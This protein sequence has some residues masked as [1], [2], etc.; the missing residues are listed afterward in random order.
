MSGQQPIVLSSDAI[1][2]HLLKGGAAVMPTDTLPAMAAVPAHAGQLWRLKRRPREKPLILM[3]ASGEVLL[4]L[5]VPEAQPTASSLAHQ[6]WPGALTLVVP[7]GAD[8][9]AQAM[10]QALNPAATS[11]GLRV[12]ACQQARALL[13]KTGPLATTSCNPAGAAAALNPEQACRYFPQLPLL[14]P[15][16]WPQPLGL[17]STVLA[18]EPQNRW[19]MLRQGAVMPAGVGSPPSCFG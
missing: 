4:Q 7:V 6:H 9:A 13:A 2:D 3:A 15:L 5:A 16:D 17:A 11:L 1:A 12:P 10:L 8:P 19:Q 14:G 18:W